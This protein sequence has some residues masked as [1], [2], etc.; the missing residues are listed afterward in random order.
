MVKIT[1][2]H[3]TYFIVRISHKYAIEKPN[4]KKQQPL[5]SGVAAEKIYENTSNSQFLKK[6]S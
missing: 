5:H 2:I 3:A 6:R 4:T 1:G